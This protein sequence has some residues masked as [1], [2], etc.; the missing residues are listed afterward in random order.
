MSDDEYLLSRN[1]IETTAKT[2]PEDQLEG[3]IQQTPN[4]KLLGT[5]F[6]LF[7]YNLSNIEKEKW[8][9]GWLR[10]IGEAPVIYDS[11]LTETSTEQ[12]KQF[13]EN[14]GYYKAEVK[15]T[16]DFRKKN[17]VVTYNITFNDPFRIKT[18]FY[19][20]EDTALT[21]RVFSDS[22]NSLLRLNMRF[23]KDELQ[24]ERI[25]IE[26]LLKE[27]GYFNFS[28]EYIFYEATT[29]SEENSVELAMHIKEYSPGKPDP[30]TKVRIHPIYSIRNVSVYPDYSDAGSARE[31]NMTDTTFFRNVYFLTEGKPNIKPNAIVNRNYII[32]GSLYKLSDVTRTYRNVSALS[33]IRFTNIT[34]QEID[35][36]PLFGPGKYLDC[37]IELTQKKLQSLQA[38]IAGTNS[39]G[40][41]GVRG[42]LQYS[43]FNLFRGAEVF[44]MRITG[45][46]ESL[47]N[48]EK[49]QYNSMKEI[50]AETNIAF[51]KFFS[52]FKLEG[53]VKKFAPKTSIAVS[54]NYQSRPDFT[55][56]H[57]Q[58]FILIPLEFKSICKPFIL[59]SGAELCEDL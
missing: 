11:A 1:R 23:D 36:L 18:I 20:F 28:K 26:T 39:A 17:A 58:Q 50:G 33:I 7:L 10:K 34:F 25:R 30:I 22:L 48:R 43:N 16:V 5:R 6:Y 42:N 2:I 47:K 44:N 32:P 21:L 52:P 56:V 59:A 46:I 51:P 19:D 35:T 9:H 12:L 49:D 54:F 15:D 4:K 55:P 53:F 24:K 13:L 29:D 8:P 3:Y 27:Q 45:A 31:A 41:L 14:K 37:R 40:D 57:S 38:E